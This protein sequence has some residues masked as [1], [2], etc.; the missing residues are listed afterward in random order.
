MNV[1]FLLS[2][3][4]DDLSSEKVNNL[5]P[6]DQWCLNQVLLSRQHLVDP[7]WRFEF[8]NPWTWSEHCTIEPLE[9]G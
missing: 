9:L 5:N 2:I 6:M 7:V 8:A 3:L 1:T 4:L